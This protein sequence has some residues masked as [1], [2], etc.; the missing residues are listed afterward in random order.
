MR[1]V[2]VRI[3]ARETKRGANPSAAFIAFERL[4]EPLAVLMGTGGFRAILSRALAVSDGGSSWLRAIHVNANGMLEGL[5]EM[6]TQLTPD[7]F[8]EASVILLES[9]LQILVAFIGE[10]LTFGIVADTWPKV[11]LENLG[12]EGKNEKGK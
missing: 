1:A 2:A 12:P 9:V 10:H 6:E 7:Q 5:K 11:S 3:V 4:R 8:L